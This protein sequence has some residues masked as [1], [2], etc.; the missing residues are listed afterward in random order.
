MAVT[1]ERKAELIKQYGKDESD[2]GS[3]AVQVAL[4]TERIRGLTEH[5]STPAGTVVHTGDFKLDQTPIDGVRPNYAALNRFGAQGVDLLLSD[6]TNATR[7]GF[8]PSEASVGPSLRHIIKNA[9]G[10]VFVASFSSHI[11]RLQ[12]VCDASTAVGRKVVVTGRSMVTNTKVARELGY[13]RIAD[14]DIVDAYDIDKIPDEKIVV[15]CTGSQGE[16]LSALARM[17]DFATTSGARPRQQG[18]PLSSNRTSVDSAYS[19]TEYVYGH[20]N[21]TQRGGSS[22]QTT[23]QRGQSGAR[24]RSDADPT[25]RLLSEGQNR[26]GDRSGRDQASTRSQRLYRHGRR[27]DAPPGPRALCRLRGSRLRG[28]RRRTHGGYR[29]V[30]HGWPRDRRD[31]VRAWLVARRPRQC[32]ELRHPRQAWSS[33][34]RS[35]TRRRPSLPTTSRSR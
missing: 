3:A 11:H 21:N 20:P 35:P 5:M 8:T 23:R 33:P 31:H 17:G 30:V 32:R 7:P 25:G 9:K 16:P 26:S 13:L 27:G 19:H 15:L 29:G 22:R 34:R 10:R 12:Q 18:V 28:V 14:E 1:K 24:R 4:L 2:S 6:S